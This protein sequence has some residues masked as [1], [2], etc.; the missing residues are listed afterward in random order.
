MRRKNNSLTIIMVLVAFLAGIA[1][2]FAAR[3]F[4]PGLLPDTVSQA[5]GTF[6]F[7]IQVAVSLVIILI[8]G[9]IIRHKNKQ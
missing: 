3:H 1:A 5:A 4:L 6:A 9:L 7:L 2:N 8:A